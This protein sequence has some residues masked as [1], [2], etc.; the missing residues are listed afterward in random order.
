MIQEYN[1]VLRL[2]N[3]DERVSII[4]FDNKAKI[5]SFTNMKLLQEILESAAMRFKNSFGQSYY[6]S[7]QKFF[8]GSNQQNLREVDQT[9]DEEDGNVK[10]VDLTLLGN[11]AIVSD[12][13]D[14]N[15]LRVLLGRSQHY[16]DK[17]M[18]MSKKDYNGKISQVQQ[19]YVN[20]IQAFAKTNKE[21]GGFLSLNSYLHFSNDFSKSFDQMFKEE[22]AKNMEINDS[23]DTI[24]PNDLQ[25]SRCS[26]NN[27][28]IVENVKVDSY[29]TPEPTKLESNFEQNILKGIH[30][31][32]EVNRRITQDG[33]KDLQN[34]D[35]P[36][37][38]G[39]DKREHA[40]PKTDIPEKKSLKDEMKSKWGAFT[41][42]FGKDSG[43]E[44]KFIAMQT[45][46]KSN[47]EKKLEKGQ[48]IDG[49]GNQYFGEIHNNKKEGCGEII[50]VN[51]D[52]YKGEFKNDNIYG[53]GTYWSAQGVKMEGKFKNTNTGNGK[54]YFPDGSIYEGEFKD[55]KS[56]GVGKYID[57]RSKTIYEGGWKNGAKEGKLSFINRLGS[58]K[59][60]N[61]GGVTVYEGG[62]KKDMKHGKGI[63][64]YNFG[65]RYVGDFVN[66]VR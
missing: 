43:F 46:F 2:E 33:Q 66:G 16:F 22:Q 45:K 40:K 5:S 17:V 27:E 11:E 8:D 60:S 6:N 29:F 35:Y 44:K 26:K 1:F 7:N 4:V 13:E 65:E 42:N 18:K 19:W 38:D 41:G 34:V 30:E 47:F 32:Q 59:V 56:H 25:I 61:F 31:Q 21:M 36:D 10:T 23:F 48:M 15:L 24:I 52:R 39:Q 28:S 64:Y 20:N 53:L 54:I 9:I 63:M 50:F 14:L 49:I 62:Y 12:Y 37:E 51:G 58:G 3:L 57:A 55:F